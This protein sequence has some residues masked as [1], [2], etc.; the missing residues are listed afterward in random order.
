MIVEILE[1]LAS[2]NEVLCLHEC[3]APTYASYMRS[4]ERSMR[5]LIGELHDVL[6]EL[7]TFDPAQQSDEDVHAVLP[8]L[9]AAL[10]Q[11]DALTAT[12]VA[13]FDT[14]QLAERDGFQATRTWLTAHGRLS[15]G[16][17]SGLL[18]RSRTLRQLPT[19]AAA[20]GAG[21]VSPEQ[22]SIVAKLAGAI[23]L[24]NVTP[25][26]QVLA[27]LAASAGPAEVARACERIHAHLDPDGA[28]PD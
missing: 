10:N 15:Q 22:V 24:A 11:L 4:G 13:S 7:A 28:A 12:I 14:R 20:A 17:A 18:A 9:L 27:D 21:R 3:I 16:A 5:A 6:T 23:G 19:L 1:K 26:D 25:F 2:R 8:E